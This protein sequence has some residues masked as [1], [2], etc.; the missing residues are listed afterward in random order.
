MESTMK[1]KKGDT[2]KVLSGKDKGKSGKIIRLIPKKG[3]VAIEGL[4]VY[5]KH[6]KPKK[7]G[8]KGEIIDVVRPINV[9]NVALM[10][11]S[12]SKATRIGMRIDDG[13]KVRYC[14]KCNKVI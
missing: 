10:C 7:E 11:P 4:N 6:S 8:E 2:V 3:R 5:K 9:S 12:C 13:N 14:K 1:I